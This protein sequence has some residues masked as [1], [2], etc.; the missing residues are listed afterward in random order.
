MPRMSIILLL[1]AAGLFCGA[2]APGFIYTNVTVPLTTDM[3]KAPRGTRLA[4]LDT[5]QLK[6]PITRFNLSAEWASRAIGDAA[7]QAGLATIFYADM[8]T[9]SILGGVWRQ[10]IVRVWGE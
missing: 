10:Q 3:D 6:E 1:I 4:S 7:K 9:I 5:K 8:K 2:C